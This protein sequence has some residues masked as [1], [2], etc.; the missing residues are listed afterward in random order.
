[1]GARVATWLSNLQRDMNNV[2]TKQFIVQTKLLSEASPS[3]EEHFSQ[4]YFS[5]NQISRIQYSGRLS[6]SDFLAKLVPACTKRVSINLTSYPFD[7]EG[8]PDRL[9]QNIS[10]TPLVGVNTCLV[11]EN[12]FLLWASLQSSSQKQSDVLLV[13]YDLSDNKAFYGSTEGLHYSSFEVFLYTFRRCLPPNAIRKVEPRINYLRELP[14]ADDLAHVPDVCPIHF[15]HY[16]FNNLGHIVRLQ[17]LGLLSSFAHIYRLSIF[18][19]FADNESQIFFDSQS[20]PKL[21]IAPS[22]Q[23][24]ILSAKSHNSSVF[25]TKDVIINGAMWKAMHVYQHKDDCIN[26]DVLKICIGVRG[27]TRECLNILE[28]IDCLIQEIRLQIDLPIVLVIDGISQSS[29]NA[30]TTTSMLSLEYELTIAKSIFNHFHLDEKVAVQSV[31]GLPMLDQLRHIVSCNFAFGH[32]GSS[33]FKYMYLAGLPCIV[34]GPN[35]GALL[36]ADNCIDPTWSPIEIFFG[37]EYISE[38]IPAEGAGPFYCNY[39]FDISKLKR[40]FAELEFS[41]FIDSSVDG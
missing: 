39:R 8:L 4:E 26:A 40:G 12:V 6:V 36:Y 9:Q 2:L 15:G 37:R 33:T 3:D 30:S 32:Q 29:T 21:K 14:V 38:V 25:C 1:M 17:S 35:T 24:A 23:E 27:G 11:D 20:R 31:V 19:F 22:I 10:I 41:S 28:A 34:H 18:D 5:I 13:L 7:A 16:I